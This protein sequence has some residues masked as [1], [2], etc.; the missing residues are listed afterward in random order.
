MMVMCN[1]V[2]IGDPHQALEEHTV[3]SQELTNDRM[4][5]SSS[6]AGILNLWVVAPFRVQTTLVWRPHIRYF[7]YD[8]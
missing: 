2:K 7:H 3:N 5:F 6:E 4:L 1:A 8:S